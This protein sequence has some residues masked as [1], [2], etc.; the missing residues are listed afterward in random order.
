MKF[1]EWQ[2]IAEGSKCDTTS[3]SVLLRLWDL[4]EVDN[5][6]ALIQS[7]PRAALMYVRLF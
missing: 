1:W 2:S 5:V 4:A 7:D 3:L 6:P